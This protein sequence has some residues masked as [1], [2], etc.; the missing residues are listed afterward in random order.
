MTNLSNGQGLPAPSCTLPA[1]RAFLMDG[2]GTLYTG[3]QPLPGARLLI[4]ALQEAGV[5]YLLLTNNATRTP[6]QLAAGMAEIGLPMGV[7]H[8]FT[9]AQATTTWLAE[10]YGLSS[11]VLMVGEVGLERALAEAGFPLVS[12]YRQ[13]DLVVAGLDRQATYARLAEATLAIRRGCPFIATNP[14]RSIPTERG[15]EPGAGAVMA[16]LEAATDVQPTLIGKPQPDFFWQALARVGTPAGETVMIG[17]RYETDILGG[18][19][20]G[21]CTA[22]VLTGVTTA[23]V[24]A[25]ADPPATWVFEDLP[26]LLAAW[27]EGTPAPDVADL[28]RQTS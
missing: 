9:S 20:A 16:F 7:E 6:E 28:A 13:A 12:D 1:A 8:I 19:R 21:M 4:E 2:D 25:S 24:F 27:R 3:R 26:E 23:E 5:P 14:D 18:Y 22:A 15:I 10:R 11:R 17:D